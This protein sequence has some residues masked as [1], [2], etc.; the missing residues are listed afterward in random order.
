MC[1]KSA[2]REI[3]QLWYAAQL[4]YSLLP[5][6]IDKNEM[7][8][9]VDQ[10]SNESEISDNFYM[11]PLFIYS[12]H[13]ASCAIR[14]YSIDE[15]RNYQRYKDYQDG[16]ENKQKG[17]RLFTNPNTGRMIHC[18]LRNLIAHEE[19]NG[20]NKKKR[21]YQEL[22]R[23]YQG[24]HF[25]ELQQGMREVITSIANDLKRDGIVVDAFA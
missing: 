6:D 8:K 5:K 10:W 9:T 20:K 13:L 4:Y 3:K 24:L 19:E 16:W 23:Y 1:S 7:A 14:L 21:S 15:K 11:A 2:V 25:Y 18:V 17:K 22:I 12:C